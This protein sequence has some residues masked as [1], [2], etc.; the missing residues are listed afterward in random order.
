MTNV[1]IVVFMV[2]EHFGVEGMREL[3][4]QLDVFDVDL[5]V[6]LGVV[7]VVGLWLIF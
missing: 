3:L 2:I 6:L 7:D 1:D 4:W 5:V